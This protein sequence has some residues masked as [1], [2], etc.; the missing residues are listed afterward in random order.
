MPKGFRLHF[1]TATPSRDPWLRALIIVLTIIASLY[2]GQMIWNLV[3]QIADLILVFAFA[4]I[5]SFVLQPSVTAL[6]RI[7]W[8]PRPA[9]VIT[10]YLALL[11]ALIVAGITLL[12]ALAAQS[13]LVAAETPSAADQLAA[14]AIGITAF[15]NERGLAVP[16]YSDQLPRTLEVAGT[17]IVANAVTLVVGAGS[18]LVQVVLTLVL[19]LYLMLDG[20]RIGNY[21][22]E[23]LPPRYRDD[24]IYFVSSVYA[25]F[26]GFLRGQIIQSLVY[27]IGIAII[28][29]AL[30][31]PFVAL[32][33]VL[34]A[35]AIFIPF[36]GPALGVLPPVLVVLATDPSR[37][38]IVLLLTIALNALVINFVAP[39]VMSG[40]IGL[41]PVVVLGAFLI[42][43]RLAGPW[44]AIFAVPV[45]A[46]IGAMVSFYKLN[47]TERRELVLEVTGAQDSAETAA[48]AEVET[49][50]EAIR[51]EHEAA[52]AR[53]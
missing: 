47:M 50:V 33:S 51:S 8:L 7:P 22:R 39:K 26:G 46:V 12:P 24:F 3:G 41:H 52:T 18:V 6:A 27:G 17:F 35:I 32:A 28:M 37:A 4:W 2:L 48:Q 49:E 45:A 25:A 53:R 11:L 14:L 34:A 1:D 36:V 43:A 40:Q 38:P 21:L 16:N 30:G 15:L 20:N 44:G 10:V 5:I 23:A 13:A 42:G 9:A 31:L 29:A 19:S